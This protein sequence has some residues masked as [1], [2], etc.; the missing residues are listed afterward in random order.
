MIMRENPER[1]QFHLK[2]GER[3]VIDEVEI[4]SIHKRVVSLKNERRV[5]PGTSAICGKVASRR[6]V[7]KF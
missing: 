2:F 4:W 3:C 5:L 7:E 1:Y 6:Q